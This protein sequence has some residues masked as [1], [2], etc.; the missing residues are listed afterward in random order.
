MINCRKSRDMMIE[1]LYGEL[2]PADR[3]SFD[4]HL[5]SCP[6]CASEYSVMGAALRV[7]DERRRPDPGPEFWDGYWDRLAARLDVTDK[8]PAVRPQAVPLSARLGRLFSGLPGWT[9]QAAAGAA[10]V[11]VGILIGRGIVSPPGRPA[12]LVSAVQNPPAAASAVPASND[13][14]ERARRYIDRSQVLLLGLV[15]YNPKT[16]DLYA[17]DLEGKKTA[18]REL[19]LQAADIESSLK[20]PRQKRLRELVSDLQIIMMQIANLGAGNDL[21]GVELVKQGVEQRDIFLK[22]DLNRMALGTAGPQGPS[23]RGGS[24]ASGAADKAKMRI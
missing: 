11:V 15:N 3:E 17:L 14:S 12:G 1:A 24:Q 21:D 16:Q 19:S 13:P 7:M 20:D 10:L 18:C 8:A 5:R 9:W 22:I 6:D 4:A 23:A 2:R